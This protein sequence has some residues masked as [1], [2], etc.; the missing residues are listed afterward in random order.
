[1]DLQIKGNAYILIGGSRGMGWETARLLA[2]E[3]ANIAIVSR[4]PAKASVPADELAARTGSTIV[5]LA[6]DVTQRGSVENS[7]HRAIDAVGKFRGIAITNFSASH[8]RPFTDI[9][10]EE[11]DYFYEDVL[12]G[13]V[14]ACKAAIPHLAANGGGQIVLTSAYSARVPKSSLVAYAAFKAALLNLTKNLSKTYGAQ[15]IRVNCVCPGYIET[16]RSKA[17]LDAMVGGEFAERRDAEKS[18]LAQSGMSVALDRLGRAH[19][20]AE[21]ITFLLSERAAYT[22]GLIANVDGGTDF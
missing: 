14:R 22:T 2:Q 11:W 7:I 10:E 19:E 18:L 13:T 9:A 21:M 1:M 4:D 17:R 20:V 12:M 15:G 6:G 3:G 16:E 8:S 5:C